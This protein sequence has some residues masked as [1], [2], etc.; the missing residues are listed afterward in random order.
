MTK[1]KLFLLGLITLIGFPVLGYPIL[2]FFSGQSFIQLFHSQY[3]IITQMVVGSTAGALFGYLAWRLMNLSFIQAEL[4][5]HLQMFNSTELT[6]PLILFISFCAGFGEEVFFR[7]I[8][9]PFLGVIITAVL[10]VA[11]HGYLN[12]KKWQISIYG[13]YMTI[14]IVIIGYLSIYVGLV[15]AIS[16]H[17]L[18][19]VVLLLY[20]RNEINNRSINQLKEDVTIFNIEE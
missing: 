3:S 5:K 20:T 13:I 9:Q 6:T 1:N 18:I 12:P 4:S 17:T 16:A 14:A 11:I 2:Y 15:S 7:G 19:D 10:F 8:V